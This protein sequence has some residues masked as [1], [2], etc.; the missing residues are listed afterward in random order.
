M[1]RCCLKT[2]TVAIIILSL[3]ILIYRMKGRTMV[4]QEIVFLVS[5]NSHQLPAEIAEVVFKVSKNHLI[6]H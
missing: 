1:N 3:G 2:T 5:F 6:K 4:E